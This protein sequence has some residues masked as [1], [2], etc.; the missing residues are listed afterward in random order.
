M[1]P[2]GSDRSHLARRPFTALT[3][4]GTAAHHTFEVSAGV[5]LVFEPFL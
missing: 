5:G 1:S 2:A 3:A 4:I